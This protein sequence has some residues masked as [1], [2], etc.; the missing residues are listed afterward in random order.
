VLIVI[1]SKK[2]FDYNNKPAITHSFDA[3][4]A[5]ENLA[6]QGSINGLVIHGM[7]GFD[8]D[9]ARKVLNVP[10]E[11]DVEAMAAIGKPGR[12]ENLPKE[13]QEKEVPSGRKNISEIAFEGEFK[14]L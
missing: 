4:A 5:W 10:L 11:Y 12:K 3:G 2:T 7:Q 13:L 8:Y 14:A 9:K 1:L 6:L